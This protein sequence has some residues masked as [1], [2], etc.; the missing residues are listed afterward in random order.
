MLAKQFFYDRFS[1]EDICG[2]F[3]PGHFLSIVLFFASMGFAL[4]WSRRLKEKTVGK[5]HITAAVL[6]TVMELI[7]ISLRVYKGQGPDDWMPL[8]YCSLFLFAVWFSL[9]KCGA[10]RNAGLA[11]ITMGGIAAAVF[12]I[13]YPTTSLNLFPIWHPASIHSFVYHWIMCYLG[14]LVLIKRVYVPKAKHAIHYGVFVLTA[15]FAAYFFNEWLGSNCMFLHSAFGLAFLEGIL[16]HSHAA[17]IVIVSLA[18]GVA[19]YWFSFGIC[20]LIMKERREK[21][22]RF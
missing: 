6:V 18:Q 16:Q 2:M 10:L 20:R 7:K 21:N 3:T 15:C 1:R 17:Y 4:W 8:Y 14:M 5:V 12:F 9:A 13:F 11:F 19:L 22:E